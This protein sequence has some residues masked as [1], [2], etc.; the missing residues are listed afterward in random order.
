MLLP[1]RRIFIIT[2]ICLSTGCATKQD[3]ERM[4]SKVDQLIQATHRSVLEEIFGGQASRIILMATDLKANQQQHFENL[5]QE[6]ANGNIAVAEVRQQ[7]LTILGNND[8][9]VSTKRGFL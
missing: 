1:Y 8:R 9:V 4:E 5:Q 2:L 6:Y 7:M 3:V